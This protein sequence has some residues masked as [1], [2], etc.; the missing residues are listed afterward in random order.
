MSEIIR[1]GEY[2]GV[3]GIHEDIEKM[4]LLS[5]GCTF[6]FFSIG[7]WVMSQL[8]HYYKDNLSLTCPQGVIGHSL[9]EEDLRQ[10][11]NPDQYAQ[12]DMARLKRHLLK[13]SSFKQC[14]MNKCNYIGWIDPTQ[15]C[16]ENLSC[17]VC[18]G[19]WIEPSLLPFLFR[20]LRNGE[21]LVKGTN[22]VWSQIWKEAWAKFCPR[23]DSPIEKNGGCPHMTCQNCTYEFCW[24]CLQPYRSHLSS[25]CEISVLYT[26]GLAFVMIIGVLI[27]FAIMSEVFYLITAF[28]FE[29]LIVLLVGVTV[30]LVFGG[31][32][33]LC[34]ELKRRDFRTTERIIVAFV[35]LIICAGSIGV[36]ASFFSYF[37]K[38]LE[39]AGVIGSCF[40]LTLGAL[41]LIY[42]P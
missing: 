8:D 30:P 31:T 6:C 5:C 34:F 17:S 33:C 15:T 14:P 1:M 28:L 36:I 41:T 19:N 32:A 37:I 11:L 20:A 7:M 40:G 16:R 22:D 25:L 24:G 21:A 10:C 13:D 9:S 26:W 23:C 38:V 42:T 29:K 3:C 27:R 4:R 12:Y 18:K 39:L 35:L 2:C